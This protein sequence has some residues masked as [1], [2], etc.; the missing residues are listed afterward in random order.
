LKATLCLT[1]VHLKIY[2]H[3]LAGVVAKKGTEFVYNML[4]STV[5]RRDVT[6]DLHGDL[7]GFVL[8]RYAS[9]NNA[10]TVTHPGVT[11]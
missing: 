8:D 1:Y 10:C 6:S 7:T 5:K 11:L 4:F 3:A 2:P 9:L